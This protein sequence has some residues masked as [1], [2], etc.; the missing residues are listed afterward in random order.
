M[1]RLTLT[2]MSV[3]VV[4]SACSEQNRETP[5]EPNVQSP[6]A[7][8]A[9]TGTCQNPFPTTAL[10]SKTGAMFAGA[11]VSNAATSKMQSVQSQCAKGKVG[12][13]RAEALTFVDWMLKKYKDGQLPNGTALKLTAQISTLLAAVGFQNGEIDP[14]AFGPDGAAGVYDGTSEF[15]IQNANKSASFRIPASSGG[16]CLP[17]S[18]ITMIRLP[19]TPQ[20]INTGGRRQFAPFYDINAANEAGD[21]TLDLNNCQE[22]TL[23]FCI[24][25]AGKENPQIGHNLA[26]DLTTEGNEEGDFEVL[27]AAGPDAYANL[28][29]AILPHS[30]EPGL[31]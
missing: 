6:S 16:Q 10:T 12:N 18:L 24:D 31:R 7:A 11:S 14:G 3:A 26:D 23:G 19:N 21:H 29:L 22:Y 15:R 2:A 4:L 17:P 25:N 13:A 5:T 20:L 27:Q 9:A 8:K 1:R 28:D 30:G